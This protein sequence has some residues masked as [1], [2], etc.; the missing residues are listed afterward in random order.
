VPYHVRCGGGIPTARHGS[1][2]EPRLHI[3]IVSPNEM[4]PAAT[5]AIKMFV[6]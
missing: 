6:T 2:T 5:V 1:K 3:E 4:M